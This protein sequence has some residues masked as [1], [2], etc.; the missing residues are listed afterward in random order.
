MKL[1]YLIALSGLFF[2]F[3]TANNDIKIKS[4]VGH[5]YDIASNKAIYDEYH[6]EQ[7]VGEKH[8]STTTIYKNVGGTILAK[9]KLNFSN[10]FESPGYRLDV[11]K[12]GYYEGANVS[13]NTVKVFHYDM[14]EKKEH[15][16]TLTVPSPFVIDGGFNYFIKRKWNTVMEGKPVVFNFVVP[17]RLDFYKFRIRKEKTFQDKGRN[18][19]LIILEPDNFIIRSIVD[20]IKITYDVASKRIIKYEGIS[21]IPNKE[22]NFEAK[23]MYPELGA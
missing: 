3:T 19:V 20:P 8:V 10:G 14:E 11:L 4:Y 22:K 17:A 6:E 23:L 5:A 12:S 9:R 13:A 2:C 21:N 7:F 1:S 16:K 15:S 18:A